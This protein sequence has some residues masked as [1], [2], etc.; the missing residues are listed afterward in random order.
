MNI[1][2]KQRI[3]GAIVVA[4]VIAIFVPLLFHR[5]LPSEK[6]LDLSSNIPKPPAEPV[7]TTS[8]HGVQFRFE[9]IKQ[10]PEPKLA[11]MVNPQQKQLSS[12][13]DIKPALSLDKPP[14]AW[15]VKLG[16][17]ANKANVDRLVDKL[18]KDG[19]DAYEKALQRQNKTY[20]QVYVGPEI[21]KQKAS[22]IQKQLASQFKLQGVVVEY[23]V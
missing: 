7:Y 13:T 3:V 1:R 21:R 6:S 4:A 8:N 20:T 17:F 9:N 22:D 11:A 2:T 18:R 5:Q 10:A 14:Q 15:V 23:Q 19:Y 16:T 12:K